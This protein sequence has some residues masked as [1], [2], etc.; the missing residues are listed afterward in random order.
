MPHSVLILDDDADFNSLLT[1]IFEQADYVVTSLTDPLQAIHVFQEQHF[2]VVVTDHKMPEMSGAAFMKAIKQTRPEIPVI[3]VSGY[4]ENDTIREL[5]REGV[6]GVFLKP[7]NIFSLL[8][9][10]TELIEEAKKLGGAVDNDGGSDYAS[11]VDTKLGFPFRSFP[12]KSEASTRFAERLHSL[13]DF[14]HSLTLTGEKGTHYRSICDD[15]LGFCG[16]GEAERFVYL[17]PAS[18]DS[19]HTV[20]LIRNAVERGAE[21]VTCVLL[22]I[23][24]MTD[25]QKKLAVALAKSERD[26]EGIGVALRTVFCVGGDLDSLFDDGVIDENL[27]ILMGTAEVRVPPLRECVADLGLIA[28]QLLV[29]IAHEKGMKAVPRI[30][31]SARDLLKKQSWDRNYEELQSTLRRAMEPTPVEV[32]T[33]DLLKSALQANK[34][35]SPRARLESHLSNQQIDFMRAAAILLD[36][37]RSDVARFFATDVDQ[38]TSKLK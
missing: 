9:R 26:F 34:A 2:D 5:I 29:D 30:E 35:A 25:S 6:G 12:C 36:G 3:M 20:S 33:A 11:E 22:G 16:S 15:I 18:F 37:D 8:E 13:R 38:I 24:S 4:L 27:Y 32:L 28:Q 17:E 7:L 10:T 1:D 23:E 31:R 14:E 21:R 19:S